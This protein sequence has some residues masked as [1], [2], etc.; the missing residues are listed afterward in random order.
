MT[1]ALR[2]GAVS[3]LNTKP[4]VYGLA[5]RA[6]QADIV[7]D[8]P[9]RLADRLAAGD[10]DV[11]LIPSIEAFQDPSYT[12]VSDACIGCR[13]PVLSVK[14]LC[15]RPAREL[16]TLALDEG[17]R[18][19]AALVRIL[20]EEKFGVRP[21]RE[22][23]PIGSGL[24]DTQADGVLL[25]GD[26]AMPP[27]KE[28]FVE[29]WDLGETWR[30]WSGLPFVFAMWTAR[31]GVDCGAIEAALG[32]ARNAGVAHLEEIAR[33]EAGPAGLTEQRCLTYL[34][35]NLYFYLGPREQQGLELYYQHAARLG[36]APEGLDLRFY[37]CQT[38]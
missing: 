26:R 37:G 13:G 28:E 4:L 32:E 30:E 5:E 19:S 8:L 25:I 17:S 7:F 23:L 9:S 1:A 15:R 33:R 14:L 18:T 24:E 6:P 2:I 3:Y 31:A 20:L 34:R 22:R 10:L 35:D 27:A 12:I 16:R 29:T 21:K 11:A 38:S 36:L